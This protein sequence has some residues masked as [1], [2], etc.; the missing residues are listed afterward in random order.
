[1]KRAELWA[2]GIVA[3]ASVGPLVE[4]GYAGEKGGRCT[5]AT[6][7]GLYMFAQSGAWYRKV[8]PARLS[9]METVSRQP[10]DDQHRRDYY[11]RRCGGRHLYAQ[12]GLHG[13]RH[14]SDEGAD[15]RRALGYFCRARRRQVFHYP[16]R[17]GQCAFRN[18]TEGGALAKPPSKRGRAP[19][20]APSV[21]RGGR[22]LRSRGSRNAP[23][24]RGRGSRS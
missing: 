16:D 15:S 19:E 3:L 6:L 12:F 5:L 4:Q 23:S 20:G 14:C 24:W 13:H 21:T 9:F 17:S 8:S 2:I 22:P 10:G 1:M 7:R 18:R 11:T